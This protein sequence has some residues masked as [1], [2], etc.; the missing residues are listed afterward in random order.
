VTT[1]SAPDFEAVADELLNL[2]TLPSLV[3]RA[4][5]DVFR[6]VLVALQR[7]A[8]NARGAADIA[9]IE[10]TLPGASSKALDPALRALDR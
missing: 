9:T 1:P 6:A 2:E 5:R 7:E 4:N 3:H 10:A 8:W